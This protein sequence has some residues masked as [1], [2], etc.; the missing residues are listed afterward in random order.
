MFHNIYLNFKVGERGGSTEN[1]FRY[2]SFGPQE[3]SDHALK[4]KRKWV[5]SDLL[6]CLLDY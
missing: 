1:Q 3:E 4:V 5:E 2:A 6:S